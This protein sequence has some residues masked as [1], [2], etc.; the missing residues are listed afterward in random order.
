MRVNHG[1]DFAGVNVLPAGDDH[2]LQTIENVEVSV[3]ILIADIAGA[4]EAVPECTLCLVR[5]VPIATHDI[6][7]AG[8]QLARLPGFDFLPCWID[9]AHVDSE[10]RPTARIELIL[11]VF[12]IKQ[13]TEDSGF[14]E[15]V[16]MNELKLS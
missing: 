11:G 9:N 3:C 13:A 10:A 2:V 6:R 5:V 4:K 1:L 8:D 15:C 16:D 12:V 7:A 14:T